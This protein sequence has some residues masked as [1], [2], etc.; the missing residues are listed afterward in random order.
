MDKREQWN[1]FSRQ[2]ETLRKKG[3]RG[4]RKLDERELSGLIDAYQGVAADLARA[5]SLGA[6]HSTVSYL[7]RL[8]VA[9]HTLLYGHSRIAAPI[10]AG[11]WPTAFARAVR[12]ARGPVLAAF[13]ALFVPAFVSC[14][15]ILLHPNL[16]FDLVDPGFYNFTPTN[17]EHMHEIPQ[18]MRPMTASQI[19]S[20]NIQV[21]FLAFAM[22]LTLGIGTTAVLIFNGV[23]LGSV[24]GW[25]TYRGQDMALLGWI[26]PH[27]ST[28]LIAVALSGAAG[29]L[30]AQAILAPGLQ[31]RLTALR[32]AAT[33]A[34]IIEFGC[35]FM[36]LVA[37]LIEGLVS[38]SSLTLG[39]RL[40][41]LFLSLGAW[42]LYFGWAGRGRDSDDDEPLTEEWW[43]T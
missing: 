13:L 7:N 31:P 33:Q 6:P 21:T 40:V 24:I 10:S 22:G 3:R 32:R 34:L 30:M 39:P 9:G 2:V 14:F 12:K 29:Y 28:E 15:A 37:G 5:R 20:N 17:A 27:G 8:A 41:I 25:M 4:L 38:P 43:T 19:I 35:M 1:A 18:L 16:A 42:A 26:L 11:R 23:H 36:L